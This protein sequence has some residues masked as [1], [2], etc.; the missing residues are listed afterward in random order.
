M[1]IDDALTLQGFQADRKTEHPGVHRSGRLSSHRGSP[2]SDA[3]LEGGREG[4]CGGRR[5]R[6]SRAGPY[7]QARSAPVGRRR[8]AGDPD[9]EAGDEI[10][11][12]AERHHQ[13]H[14]PGSPKRSPGAFVCPLCRWAAP[15]AD[16]AGAQPTVLADPLDFQEPPVVGQWQEKAIC[17]FAKCFC[18][19]TSNGRP[20]KLR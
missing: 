3:F 11:K 9:C 12:E 15:R 4:P 10:G 19:L 2:R 8:F 20:F 7:T 13:G 17:H 16:A 18:A 5:G 14:H 1:G 6:R